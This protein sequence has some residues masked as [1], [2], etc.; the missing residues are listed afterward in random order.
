MKTEKSN[1]YTVVLNCA[2]KHIDTKDDGANIRAF[3]K[4]VLEPQDAP[5]YRTVKHFHYQ[6]QDT[7]D[8]YPERLEIKLN[9]PN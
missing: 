2:T 3:D 5:T 9:N 4:Y 8:P 6:K 1:Y 7:E